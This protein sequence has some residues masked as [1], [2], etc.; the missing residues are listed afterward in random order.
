MFEE[1]R[2]TKV[3]AKRNAVTSAYEPIQP[4]VFREL[5]RHVGVDTFFDIGANIGLYTILVA[6]MKSVGRVHSFEPTEETFMHLVENVRLNGLEQQVLCHQVVLSDL[7]RD[8]RFGLVG[9]VSG[10]NGVVET[11]IH[12]KRKFRKVVSYRTQ[13][14]DAVVGLS[15]ARI[16]IKLDV[17][18][19]ELA[20][21]RGA[22][23]LLEGNTGFAQIEIYDP[24]GEGRK[25]IERMESHSWPLVLRLGPDHYFTN[26]PSTADPQVLKSILESAASEMIAAGVARFQGGNRP[27]RDRSR[28]GSLSGRLRHYFERAQSRRL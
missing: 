17:E 9:D 3:S 7:E 22:C 1:F 8:V 5:I 28:R 25:V 26:E 20:V 2:W 23:G 6:S 10:A 14:L 12:D 16:A 19:H 24:D 4:F 13:L 18:G 15:G 11:T 21:L 27:G